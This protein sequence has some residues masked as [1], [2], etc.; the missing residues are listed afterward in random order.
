MT[1]QITMKGGKS[2]RKSAPSE[3]AAKMFGVESSEICSDEP[4]TTGPGIS[5]LRAALHVLGPGSA[6]SIINHINGDGGAGIKS[7]DWGYG[8][9]RAI[10]EVPNGNFKALERKVA[11]QVIAMDALFATMSRRALVMA[12]EGYTDAAETFMRLA[13]KAQNQCRITLD[14]LA[15]VKNPQ[16]T[17]FMKQANIANGPQQVNNG[18]TG[19]DRNADGKAQKKNNSSKNKL[20]TADEKGE[21]LDTGTTGK[22]V[23]NDKVM[24]PVGAI[25][26]AKNR[27]GKDGCIEKRI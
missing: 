10:D 26:R 23:S 25:H 19:D 21:R 18:P 2:E 4:S 12:D 3:E 13:L 15:Q 16:H 9:A 8:V 6:A 22:T 24:E 14:T 17:V 11:A 5:K 20:L 1:G 27:R 7:Y